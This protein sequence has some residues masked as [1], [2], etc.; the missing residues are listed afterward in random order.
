VRRAL[1]LAVRTYMRTWHALRVEGTERLPSR[2]PM[3]VMINHTSI[4]DVPALMAADPYPNT[5]MVVKAAALRWP[6]ARRI[7]AA[8]WAIGV[9]RDGRDMAGARALLGALCQGRVVALAP[10]GQRARDGRLGEIRP[11]FGRLAVRASVPVVPVGIA[12][13]YEALPPGARFPR[14]RPIVLRVGEP[15]HFERGTPAEEAA[16]RI[17]EAIAALLPPERRSTASQSPAEPGKTSE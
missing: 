3:L 6:V 5:T 12:G 10:E 4:L 13:S 15:L 1:K 9:E 8:W 11:L 16:R 14:P 2:G 7:L 17:H